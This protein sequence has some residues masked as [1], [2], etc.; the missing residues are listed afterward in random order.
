L[1]KRLLLSLRI[2]MSKVYGYPVHTPTL[3]KC[4]YTKK[5]EMLVKERQESVKEA[6]TPNDRLN[7]IYNMRPRW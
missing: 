1:F 3:D 4:V 5:I 7:P 2:S 6:P